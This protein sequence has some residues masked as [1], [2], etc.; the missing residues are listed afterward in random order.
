MTEGASTSVELDPVVRAA[1]TDLRSFTY[2]RRRIYNLRLERRE[3]NLT[4]P[5]A[6]AGAIHIFKH[7]KHHGYLFPPDEV[8][9]WAVANRWRPADAQEL[10]E[11]AEGILAGRRY[12][13]AP[14]PFGKWAIERRRSAAAETAL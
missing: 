12:H 1:L 14:D 3:K 4:D 2:R 11:Y 5:G 7:L 8:R 13:T 6:R 9:A 10:G